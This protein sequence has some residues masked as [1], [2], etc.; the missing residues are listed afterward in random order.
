MPKVFVSY[1]H[2]QG[3]W[4]WGRLVPVLRA[5][6][7]EVLIDVERFKA[8]VSCFP[9]MDAEQDAADYQVLCFS[10]EYMQSKSCTREWKRAVN[11]DS[12]FSTGQIIPIVL[13]AELILP[14]DVRVPNPLYVDMRRDRDTKQ[15]ELLLRSLNSEWNCCPVSWLS[16]AEGITQ[17]LN[18]GRCVNLLVPRLPHNGH[19][20]PVTALITHLQEARRPRALVPDLHFLDLHQGECTTLTGLL[21]QI[22]LFGGIH[23]RLSRSKERAI[24]EFTIL[25]RRRTSTLRLVLG[26]CDLIANK[27]RQKAYGT[28]FFAT[29]FDL[30]LQEKQ[31]LALLAISHSP[32]ASLVPSDAK[33][34]SINFSLI[35]LEFT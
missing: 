7:A 19:R 17:Q 33:V 26:S 28:N 27:E 6:G 25:M 35:Q 5:A 24:A 3:E 20:H 23:Q 34:S 30:T 13:Q 9:Q 16:A 22:L 18:D 14:E 12:T 31:K 8:G 2:A 29:L 1:S 15:W 11:K 21:E 32:Y 10:E 4:V